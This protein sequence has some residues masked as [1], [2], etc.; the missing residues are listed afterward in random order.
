VGVAAPGVRAS[1][2]ELRESQIVRWVSD[3]IISVAALNGWTNVNEVR[4]VGCMASTQERHLG[5][6]TLKLYLG[7]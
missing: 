1:G 4:F 2:C 6:A 3:F 5:Q 7:A